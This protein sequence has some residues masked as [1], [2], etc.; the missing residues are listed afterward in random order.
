[1][2]TI[3]GMYRL[4]GDPEAGNSEFVL[5]YYI[6]LWQFDRSFPLTCSVT[7]NAQKPHPDEYIYVYTYIH[8]CVYC[9]Y[10]CNCTRNPE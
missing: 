7:S 3:T 9:Y 4:G 1:M 10:V 6:R 2:D 8:V 5:Q